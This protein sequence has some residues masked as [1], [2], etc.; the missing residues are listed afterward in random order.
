MAK[1]EKVI[2]KVVKVEEPKEAVKTA[3]PAI[4]STPTLKKAIVNHEQLMKLQD[5]RKLVGYDPKTGEATY[6]ED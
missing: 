2:P 6:K 4:P 5:D 3:A 1:K